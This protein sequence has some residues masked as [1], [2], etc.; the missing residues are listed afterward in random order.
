VET[1][2]QFFDLIEA[3]DATAACDV[4]NSGLLRHDDAL[5]S[6]ANSLA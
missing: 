4:M 5:A 1:Y 2:T 6:A 3:G